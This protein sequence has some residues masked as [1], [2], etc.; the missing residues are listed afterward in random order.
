MES[1]TTMH[2]TMN[3]R[4]PYGPDQ[5]RSRRGSVTRAGISIIELAIWVVIM[6]ALT[7]GMLWVLWSATR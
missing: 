5:P 2:A 4:S 1:C 6:A 7:I 3:K